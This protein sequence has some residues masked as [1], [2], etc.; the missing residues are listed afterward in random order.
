MKHVNTIDQLW[1]GWLK[2][3]YIL[4]QRN[5]SRDGPE[6]VKLVCDKQHTCFK[7]IIEVLNDLLAYIL[8]TNDTRIEKYAMLKPVATYSLTATFH[9]STYHLSLRGHSELYFY[10]GSIRGS[11]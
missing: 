5:N 4:S 9:A 1:F 11:S 2:L 6:S 7:D 8:R 10:L 3:K